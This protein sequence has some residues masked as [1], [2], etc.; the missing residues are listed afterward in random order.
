MKI[1][2]QC[3]EHHTKNDYCPCCGSKDNISD[4]NFYDL[5]EEVTGEFVY[6]DD[7]DD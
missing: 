3:G 5:E 4:E 7:E 6:E 2:T 1:C